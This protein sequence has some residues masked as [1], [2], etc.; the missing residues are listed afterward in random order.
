MT[1]EECENKI[2]EKLTEIAKIYNQYDPHDNY[3]S[4]CIQGK[5]ISA[6]NAYFEENHKGGIIDFVVYDYEKDKEVYQ[7][8]H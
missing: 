3:L 7:R 5:N 4:I 8:D 6:N 1:R 2:A